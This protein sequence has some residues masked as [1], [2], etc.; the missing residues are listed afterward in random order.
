M[1]TMLFQIKSRYRTKYSSY[2]QLQLQCHRYFS[3][4]LPE[5]HPFNISPK[6]EPPTYHRAQPVPVSLLHQINFQDTKH[7]HEIANTMRP[8]FESKNPHLLRNLYSK[9]DAIYFWR[10]LK[11]WR[12]SVGEEMDVEIEIGKGY[13]TSQ[14][15]TTKFGAYLEYLQLCIEKGAHEAEEVAY[16]AQNELFA[17]V[18]EDIPIPRFCCECDGSYNVGKGKLY[19]TMLW[20]GPS[21]TVSPLHYDPL[22]NLLVQVVGWKRVLLFP[23]VGNDTTTNAANSDDKLWHYAGVDGNQYNT[24]AVDIENPDEKKYPNFKLAPVPFECT[25]GPGDAL[26]IPKKWWHHVRSLE[27]SVSANIW[28]R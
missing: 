12:M 2:I 26:Y 20:M 17:Q 18:Q 9:C 27:F 16:L 21:N 14:R 19:H 4:W 24:S 23:P 15:V 25:L 10:S 5:N 6:L 13:N 7:Q 1:F 11:Y 8:H 3:S 28:W 22:D